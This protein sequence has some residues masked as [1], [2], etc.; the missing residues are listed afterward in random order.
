MRLSPVILSG[1]SGTRLWP[2]SRLAY[3]KQLLPLTGELSLLQQTAERARDPA[4]FAPPLVVCNEEHRFIVAEQ[5]RQIGLE[6]AA[7]VLEPAGRNTAPAA[8]IAALALIEREPDAIMLVLASDHVIQKGEAFLAAID[9]AGALARDGAMVAFGIEPNAPESGFGWIRKGRALAEPRAFAIDRFVEK[10][11]RARAE[12]FMAEGGHLWNSGMFVVSAAGYLRELERLEP[13]VVAACRAALAASRRD[14]SFVRLDRAAFE[15]SPAI[16]I[17]HAVMERTPE[18]AVVACD[19][20]WSDVG[21]WSALWG[22]AERDA[23]GNAIAGDVLARGVRNSYLRADSRLVAAL[24][25]DDVVVV[26]TADA[27]LVAAKD[28]VQEVKELVAALQAKGRDELIHHRRVW[29]PWGWYERLD[30]AERFSVKRIAVKPG[31]KLSLQMHHH[32]AEHW[33]VVKGTAKVTRDGVE[34]LVQENESTFIPL[35]VRHRL[36]NPGM[37]PLELIEVQSGA[38]LGEDDIVR[39]DDQYGRKD[40]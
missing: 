17:D 20:G 29:R 28:R 10:P 3:P 4:R 37:I 7:I 9:T 19:I 2:L 6:P 38:Y 1:G 24:G 11:D 8:A 32:R 16:S 39:F 30:G 14:L 22:I 36:E 23:D 35:G 27:V 5:L 26:E 21:S 34:T 33:I 15:A 13:A 18:R 40:G 31:G 12:R 25:L